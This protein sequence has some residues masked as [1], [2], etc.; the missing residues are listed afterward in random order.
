MERSPKVQEI[1]FRNGHRAKMVVS[2]GTDK[3]AILLDSLGIAKPPTL[4]LVTGG[5]SFFSEA[6]RKK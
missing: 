4:I 1:A 2:S 6:H 3:P 5:A